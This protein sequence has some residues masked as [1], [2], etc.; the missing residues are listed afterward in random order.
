[1]RRGRWT[2]PC[3]RP[4]SMAMEGRGG[5]HG[6]R[7]AARAAAPSVRRGVRS[8]FENG[9]EGGIRTLDRVTPI[10]HFQCRA[11][12]RTRRPLRG[13]ESLPVGAL[14]LDLG[15]VLR[16]PCVEASLAV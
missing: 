13:R 12:D 14:R 5:G 9:G 6:W 15:A 8:E 1:M 3:G 11:L 7:Q 16:P 4:R 10:R 2:W